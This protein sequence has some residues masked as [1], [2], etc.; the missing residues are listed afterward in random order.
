M[1]LVAALLATAL[2]PAAP[3]VAQGLG[4]LTGSA[5]LDGAVADA[6]ATDAA[7]AEL[8]VTLESET[9]RGEL[10]EQL[11]ALKAARAAER[12]NI[13]EETAAGGI[14]IDGGAFLSAVTARIRQ[15]GE[16]FVE[17]ARI[18]G[19]APDLGHWLARQAD[20]PIRRAQWIATLWKIAVVLAIAIV[21]ELVAKRLLQRPHRALETRENDNLG[22]RALVLGART[23]LDL[24]PVVVFALAA[25][26]ALSLLDPQDNIAAAARALV[27][28]KVLV[29]GILVVARLVL[30]PRVA[31]LRFLPLDDESANYAYIWIRR[32]ANV[33]LYGAYSIK[34]AV[35]LE[36]P[37][38][39]GAVLQQLLGLVL[40]GMTV[41]LV[42]QLRETVSAWLAGDAD[43]AASSLRARLADIWHVAAIIYAIVLYCIWLLDLDGGF[44]LIGR[45]SAVTVIALVAARLIVFGSDRLLAS[46]FSLRTETH[47]RYPGLQE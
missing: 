9:G 27:L 14:T 33:G 10:I 42:L 34:A 24:V 23:V 39:G 5:A 2:L 47:E 36:L 17:S 35:A 16:Q 3:S 28:A 26:A 7:I 38:A 4:G 19:T 44:E 29:R 30:A 25:E 22:E 21:A 18:V 43:A 15:I 1:L 13:E 12:G 45:A 8:I 46:L 41:A 11:K 20:D 31:A 6:G 32:F 37:L 40:V